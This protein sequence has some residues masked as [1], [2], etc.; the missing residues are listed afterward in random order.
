VKKVGKVKSILGPIKVDFLNKVFMLFDAVLTVVFEEIV[1]NPTKIMQGACSG[2]ILLKKCC[3]ER[4]LIGPVT[5]LLLFLPACNY[6]NRKGKT[7]SSQGK[8]TE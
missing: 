5:Y 4:Y 7:L 3:L 2:P 1:F 6:N 8:T